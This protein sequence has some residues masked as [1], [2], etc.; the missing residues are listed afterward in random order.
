MDPDQ[1]ISVLHQA[2]DQN[3]TVLS[4]TDMDWK[5]FASLY[6]A[7][8][9]STLLDELPDA[10]MTAHIPA[11]QTDSAPRSPFAQRLTGMSPAE[12]RRMLLD[13]VR[14]EAGAVLGHAEF[15]E[16]D[17]QRGFLESGFSSLTAVELRNRLN[18]VTGLKLPPSVIYDH[19]N[20]S[21]LSRH[22]QAELAQDGGDSQ[23]SLL[24]SL[25]QIEA[26]VLAE[27]VTDG[28][29]THLV[30]RL[31]DLLW[32]VD[33]GGPDSKANG[34]IDRSVIESATDDEMFALIDE[35]LGLE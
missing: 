31:R 19:P 26:A 35:E 22:L 5:R 4:V 12:Q 16:I 8:R 18:A 7:A 28:A 33:D 2:L 13:L 14:G 32:K 23:E 29:R 10:Q 20:P 21:A 15:Q 3:E 9:P 1:A 27:S 24:E 11:A 6:T 30:E 17:S 25:R 34:V